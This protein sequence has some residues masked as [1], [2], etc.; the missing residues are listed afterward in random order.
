VDR[1]KE[2][3]DGED[4]TYQ[5]REQKKRDWSPFLIPKSVRN[6]A[7]SHMMVL[8]LFANDSQTNNLCL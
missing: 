5:S 7:F 2:K 8:L 1:A 6:P 3:E 4:R